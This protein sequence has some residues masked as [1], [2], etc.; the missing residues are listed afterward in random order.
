MALKW[1]RP[2]VN[3]RF[4]ID[5]NWWTE[6]GRDIRVFMRDMLC[7]GCQSDIEGGVEE[8]EEID[9]VNERTGEVTRVDWLWHSILSCCSLKPDYISP[10]TPIIDAVFRTFLANGNR[11]LSVVEL[12][13]LLD[14]RPPATLLR[15]LTGGPVYMGIR[16]FR[17]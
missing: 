7:P 14:R 12:Y 17:E 5:M 1:Q 15:V 10:T 8:T 9:A 6:Q 2:T 3:S 4:H 16:L 13:E 11:P